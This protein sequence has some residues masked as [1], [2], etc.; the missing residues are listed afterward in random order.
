M[1]E[2]IVLIFLAKEIGA[3]ASRKGL[4]SG[5]WKFYL[6]LGWIFMELLGATI[7]VMMFGPENVI[8]IFL[9]AVAF[10]V[11]SY[12]YIKANLNKRPDS[13]LDDDIYNI[14]NKN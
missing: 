5:L 2:I 4:K 9:I 3:L 11:T 1:I 14:G 8:S 6:V 12:F 7:G 10:A 13:G